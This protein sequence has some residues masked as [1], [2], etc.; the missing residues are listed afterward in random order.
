[1]V[2]RLIL[3]EVIFLISGI[4]RGLGSSLAK[5]VNFLGIDH[6]LPKLYM[7]Q[8]TVDIH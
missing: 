5:T 4:V 1:M 6:T 3:L 2:L 8:L 7:A